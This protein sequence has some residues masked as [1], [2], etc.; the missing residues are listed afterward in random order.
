[1]N[2][3]NIQFKSYWGETLSNKCI[4]Q[5]SDVL[6]VILP[7]EGYTNDKP[8]MYYSSKISLE[9]GLDVLYVDYGFQILHKN[10]D[11]NEELDILVRESEQVLI[12]CLSENY[13]KIIFIGKSLGTIIQN[14][15]SKELRDYEQV[16]VYLTPVNETVKY[17]VN[18]PCLVVTGKDDGKINSLNMNALES[19]KNIKLVQID[20]GNHSLECLDV[21]KSI[22]MLNT[23]MRTLKN[24]L[25]HI[26]KSKI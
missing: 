7:G 13:K 8:L 18:Y 11:I 12:K 15:L 25:L 26:S 5:N 9:L 21:L 1:M 17:M 3:T 16:H 4:K 10:F 6:A 23:I 24:F 14:R 22:E 20:E 19:R 2:E